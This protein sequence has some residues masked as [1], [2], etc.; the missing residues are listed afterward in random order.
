MRIVVGRG[1]NRV[2]LNDIVSA[3]YSIF[4]LINQVWK[5]IKDIFSSVKNIM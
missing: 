5:F 2:V 4:D 3:I 1:N